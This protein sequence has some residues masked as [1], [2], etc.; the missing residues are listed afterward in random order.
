MATK[1][2]TSFST[3]REYQ[4]KPYNLNCHSSNVVYHAQNNRRSTESFQS[5][6]N[7]YKS[8]HWSFVKGNTVKQALFH[9]HF[10]DDK[11]GLSDWKLPSMIK[12]RVWTILGKE[13]LFISMNLKPCSQKDLMTM[14]WHSF[15]V[16]FYLNFWQ[17]SFS[18]VRPTISIAVC[19]LFLP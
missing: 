18:A 1:T 13:I 8:A 2:I 15:D 4:I 3:H 16:L 7:N 11:H 19:T 17:S 5:R 10:E 14:K 12:Q 9:T 6:F